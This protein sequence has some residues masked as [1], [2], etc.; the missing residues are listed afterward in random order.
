MSFPAKHFL[1]RKE[2]HPLRLLSYF[3]KSAE[4]N[5]IN[6]N[7]FLGSYTGYKTEKMEKTLEKMEKYSDFICGTVLEQTKYSGTVPN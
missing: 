6:G 5:W 7:L 4:K 2:N 3:L 1:S